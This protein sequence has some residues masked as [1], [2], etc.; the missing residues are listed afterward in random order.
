MGITKRFCLNNHDTWIVGRK[1]NSECRECCQLRQRTRYYNLMENPIRRMK[2]QTRCRIY[3][4]EKR[5]YG[6]RL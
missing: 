5:K 1:S 4:K 3:N 6:N 2:E